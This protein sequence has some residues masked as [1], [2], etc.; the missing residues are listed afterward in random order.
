MQQVN[1]V[2]AFNCLNDTHLATS[3]NLCLTTN[4]SSSSAKH[5]V[6]QSGK[7]RVLMNSCELRTRTQVRRKIYS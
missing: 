2:V 4:I 1:M 7:E 5:W 3:L 6:L